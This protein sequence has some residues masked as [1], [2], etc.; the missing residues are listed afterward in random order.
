MKI[1]QILIL[2]CLTIELVLGG[3]SSTWSLCHCSFNSWQSWSQCTAKCGGGS[4]RRERMVYLHTTLQCQTFE[5]CASNDM[6]F[7]YRDCNTICYNGGTME[8]TCGDPG[9]LTNGQR[10]GDSFDY[11][12]TVTYT[13]SPLYNM[14]QGTSVRTCN[15]YGRWTGYM[16]RCIYAHT[17][18]S[19]PCQNG[20]TCVDG[21]DSYVCQCLP[22][23]SG[24]NCEQDIQPPVMTD[25]PTNM[26]L[27]VS[28]PTVSINWSIP[29]FTDPMGTDLKVTNNYPINHWSFHWGDFTVQ[30][31]AL[32]RTNGLSTE[33][34]FNITIRPHPCP[35]LNVPSG[36]AKVC[37]GWKSDFGQ[38]CMVFCDIN[39]D[40][41]PGIDANQWYVCGASGEW[42]PSAKLPGCGASVSL[43]GPPDT[44][45][46][47]GSCSSASDIG[48]LQDKFIERL[49]NS[50]YSYFCN[51]YKDLCT[52]Q[53]VDVICS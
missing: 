20:G 53:N 22:G 52:G 42:K 13:C 50:H 17:C 38:Y 32:K 30:Y 36:G 16:P 48:L 51:V 19:N 3:R 31:S 4:Q 40:V 45:V 47:F 46:H 41:Y 11:S 10:H 8:V 43:S 2:S 37:N 14:T 5:D 9:R 12:D 7:D 25:C 49:K 34:I 1:T 23:W 18:L 24:I 27:F 29:I 35:T 21:L 44:N 15:K 6:G 28:K 39:H 33:C 26:N